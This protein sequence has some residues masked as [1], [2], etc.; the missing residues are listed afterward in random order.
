MCG[1][2]GLIDKNNSNLVYE[3]RIRS[4]CDVMIHRGPDED[5][6]YLNK[7]VALGM[8]RLKIID[9]AT[10]SQPIF[11]EDRSI[12]TVFNGEIYNFKRLKDFLLR[13][14]HNFYTNTDTEV[15]VHLY[16]DHGE[17]FL[18]YL[19]G[20]FAI[21]L[22]DAR[23]EKLILARDRLG[24]KPLHYT[25][26]NEGIIFASE[27][28]SILCTGKVKKELN[29]EAL[30]HYFSLICVPAP[31]TIFK[32]IKKLLPGHYLKYQNGKVDIKQ[33][34]DISYEPDFTKSEDYFCKNLRELLINSLKDR[35][36]SDVPLG[37]FLSG[38]IDSSIV[39][40]LMSSIMD[41]PVKTFSIGFKEDKYNELKYARIIAKR[42]KTDHHEFIVEP[43]ALDLLENLVWHF[44]EPFGGPSAIPTYIVSELAK[45]YVTVVLT[46]DGGDEIF[47]GYDSYKE[48]LKR[49]NLAFLPIWLR[50]GIAH[51]IGDRLSDTTKGKRFLQSLAL[52]EPKLHSVGISE[53]WK[54]ELFSKDF[55]K[56]VKEVDTYNVVK[57]HILNGS[58][59]YL[60]HFQ[61][62]DTKLYLPDNVLVKVDRMSMAN[63]LETR[64]LFL[65]HEIVEFAAKIPARLKLNGKIS[66]YI[67]KKSMGDLI[68]EE[69]LNRRKWGFALPV[70]MWFRSELKDLISSV[71]QKSKVN[72][73]FNHDY[74]KTILDEHLKGEK[75][76]QRLLWSFMMF[77]LWQEKY[78]NSQF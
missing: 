34:W 76:H 23:E 36:I 53:Q 55:L 12:V 37:A 4:M 65:D 20:M 78:L 49:K 59:E 26:N 24:E 77:C 50:R 68:P 31:L 54:K 38:G 69:I 30:Y 33:Y 14:G 25:I 41:K 47:A 9:L 57:P 18:R 11:N 67:L 60:T 62:L 16:E 66:K 48:R 29:Y 21:A 15:I 28:K 39:V 44:D 43:K 71:V 40:G 45:K 64:T 51:G 56:H 58:H 27:I 72:G 63:S 1:I 70:A 13:R 42:F 17:D 46:G 52:D 7:N 5:G 74:L 10:G 19:N 22:W 35:L 73:I 61:H 3:D 6:Y 8:R 75:N 2:S 32:D